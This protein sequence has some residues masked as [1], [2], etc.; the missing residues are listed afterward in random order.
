[1]SGSDG[2]ATRGSLPVAVVGS[3]AAG[4][5]A[6]FRLRE[7]G[8]AVRLLERNPRLGGKM[9]TTRREGYT[10]EEGPSAMAGSYTSILGIARGAGM[11][12]E[13]IPAS[14]RIAFAGFGSDRDA[15]HYLDPVHILRDGLRT[16]LLSPG[17][18]LRLARLGLDVWRTRD[19]RRPDDLSL[20]TELDGVTADGY[21]RARLGDEVAENLIDP[22][23]RSF[24]NCAADEVSA[25]DLIYALGSFMGSSQ[26][27]AFRDGMSSYAER[28]GS[29]CSV[30][31]GASVLSVHE[32]GDEVSVTWS[33]TDGERTERFAGVVLATD[34]HTASAVHGGLAP[35]RREFLRTGVTYTWSTVVHLA[36]ER[37][38]EV[39]S[40]F[41]FPR[42][43]EHP[44]LVIISLEHNKTPWQAPPG[45]GL[46]GIYP[47]SAHARSLFDENDEYVVKD[48]IGEAEALVPGLGDHVRFT[49]VSRWSPTLLQ[50]RP[51]YWTAMRRFTERAEAEDRRV[52]L[53]G[54]YF[55]TSSLNTASASG[56]RAARRLLG[57][58]G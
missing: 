48:L 26:Y 15:W 46:V 30:S 1:V 36:L 14:G 38:P 24:I 4:L 49:H 50:S 7:A 6:A 37:R 58:L 55:C 8:H 10:L 19:R 21:A 27:V 33:D 12:E 52:Q 34:A 29:F 2:S 23:V 41:V 18:K 11:A 32:F 56:E 20:L 31:L 42:G 43:S 44:N 16:K 39:E 57:A 47:S 3:G 35:E 53:A 5:A 51:G 22:C 25:A 40:C 45:K 13:I 17:A 9:L 28:I 54:D